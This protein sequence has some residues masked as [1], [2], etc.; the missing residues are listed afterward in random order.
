M[1]NEPQIKSLWEK[2]GG[3]DILAS[4]TFQQLFEYLPKRTNAFILQD[5][6][7]RCIDEGTGGGL[8]IAGTGALYPQVV[9]DFKGKVSGVYSH[10]DCGAVALYM[11]NE[12]SSSS[13]NNL[14]EDQNLTADKLAK[15]LANKLGVSFLGRIHASEMTRPMGLHTARVIYYDGSGHFNPGEVLGLP[16]GFVISRKLI[17]DINYAKREVEVA[18]KIA[19]GDHGFG[20]L[21]TD[22]SPLYLVAVTD[23][24]PGS[25]DVD[26]MKKELDEVARNYT[27]VKVDKI[28]GRGGR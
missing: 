13:N 1:L 10:E 11:K 16:Q 26:V 24:E 20:K 9:Q 15:D 3:D 23:M 4:R 6:D 7:L 17:S 12:Q 5:Y 22:K 14:T 27:N 19:L 18:V 8:H 28:V 21:F 2:S 25:T